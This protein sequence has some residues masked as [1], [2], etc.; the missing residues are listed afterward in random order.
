MFRQRPY[1]PNREYTP[2]TLAQINAGNRNFRIFRLRGLSAQ[3]Y[4]LTGWRR[5]LAEWA[6]DRELA[7]LGAE[8]EAKR[9]LKRKEGWDSLI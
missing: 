2:R 8:T 7:L 6:I 3:A 5:K 4:I 1:D 9:R